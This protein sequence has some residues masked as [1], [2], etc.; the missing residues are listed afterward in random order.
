MGI[1]GWT[2]FLICPERRPRRRRD[3]SWP[4]PAVVLLV[5]VVAVAVHHSAH[6]A[7]SATSGVVTSPCTPAAPPTAASGALVP[8]TA[9]PSVGGAGARDL[10]ARLLA[11]A[12]LPAGARRTGMVPHEFVQPP[13]QAAAASLVDDAQAWDVAAS[14][15]SVWA[16]VDTPTP[17]G[18]H[19]PGAG[20]EGVA[21]TPPVDLVDEVMLVLDSLP[22]GIQSAQLLVS[23]A[24]RSPAASTIRVDA[25]VISSPTKTVDDQVPADVTSMTI[26]RTPAAGV[27][28]VTVRDAVVVRRLAALIDALPPA[29]VGT[30]RLPGAARDLRGALPPRAPIRRRPGRATR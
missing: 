2:C 24:A 17:A 11:E 6:S 1:I 4:W 8:I 14:P 10:A 5:D 29:P 15:A 30:S 27:S 18:F 25:Q 28:T 26:A 13:E 7:R 19:C 22:P 20:S 12:A 3:C 23:V 16:F 21:S 9:L